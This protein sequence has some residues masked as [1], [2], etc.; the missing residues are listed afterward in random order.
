M[1][2]CQPQH[3]RKLNNKLRLHTADNSVLK[4]RI[5]G[6]DCEYRRPRR[7]GIERENQVPDL[8]EAIVRTSQ[9]RDA[10]VPGSDTIKR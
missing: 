10:G 4:Q 2:G 7:P 8:L 1:P 3:C 9:C 5:G 6:M